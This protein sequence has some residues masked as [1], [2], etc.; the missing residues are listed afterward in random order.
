M[1]D[2]RWN[3]RFGYR[4][5]LRRIR[6]N[7]DLGPRRSRVDRFQKMPECDGWSG[8]NIRRWSQRNRG[9]CFFYKHKFGPNRKLKILGH[10]GFRRAGGDSISHGGAQDIVG[11][12]NVFNNESTGNGLN[13]TFGSY[14]GNGGNATLAMGPVSVDSRALWRLAA[15]AQP[16]ALPGMAV[17]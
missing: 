9:Q 14:G 4:V 13:S 12:N 6:R 10:D 16:A 15:T 5:W 11:S 2:N 1:G 17:I 7:G 8:R 3:G